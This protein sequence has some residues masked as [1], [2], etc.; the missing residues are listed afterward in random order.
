MLH[1]RIEIPVAVKQCEIAFDAASRDNRVDGLAYGDA[2]RSQETEI[3]RGLNGNIP[4]AKP[5]HQQG[6]Q[7]PPGF[8]EIG[9]LLNNPSSF[10][11]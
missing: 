1:E 6:C 7:Q 9:S 3:P 4:T 5:N 10:S 11:V 2:L 8:I